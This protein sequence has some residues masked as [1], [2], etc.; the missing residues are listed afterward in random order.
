MAILPS[1][2]EPTTYDRDGDGI[3]DLF[4]EADEDFYYELYDNNFDGNV[5]ESWKYDMDYILLS[6]KLDHD[7]NGVLESEYTSNGIYFTDIFTD[8][9]ENGVPDVYTKMEDGTGIY[10]ESYQPMAR[11]GKGVLKRVEYDFGYP[12]KETSIVVSFSEQEFAR[13]KGWEP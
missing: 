7:F 4:V 3:D 10:A 1:C 6:A 12:S 9:N 2:S 5:D 13:Q 11:E 8:S